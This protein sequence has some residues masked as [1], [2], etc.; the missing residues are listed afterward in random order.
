MAAVDSL[1]AFTC[2]QAT[3]MCRSRPP[4]VVPATLNPLLLQQTVE[5][6][7]RARK[8][9]TR[10]QLKELHFAKLAMA[11]EQQN[12]NTSVGPRLNTSDAPEAT[13][14][15]PNFDKRLSAAHRS[16]FRPNNRVGGWAPVLRKKQLHL[17][18]WDEETEP[19]SGSDSEAEE[20]KVDTDL[21]WTCCNRTFSKNYMCDSCGSV[22]WQTNKSI[23]FEELL[24]YNSF[25]T[26]VADDDDDDDAEWER[27]EVSSVGGSS[28]LEVQSARQ[29]QDDLCSECSDMSFLVVGNSE[30]EPSATQQGLTWAQRIANQPESTNQAQQRALGQHRVPAFVPQRRTQKLKVQAQEEEEDSVNGFGMADVVD[31]RRHL[32]GKRR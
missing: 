9:A 3:A 26:E 29:D 32:K 30:E 22:W 28:W 10:A 23:P 12:Q 27:C 21:L 15:A 24:D 11:K 20:G 4:A 16:Q 19:W 18:A 31:T 1:P 25:H 14:G 2:A 7:R 8:N 13:L 17:Q 5:E 6:D